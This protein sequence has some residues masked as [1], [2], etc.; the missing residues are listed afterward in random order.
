LHGGQLRQIS[1][2]FNIPSSQL[3]D[4]SANIN[5]DGPPPGVIST[6][7]TSVEDVS[8]LTAYPDLEQ[9]AL[10]QSIA[11]YGGMGP[12]NLAV[13][14]GF[15]PLLEA[16]LRTLNIKRCLL[17]VPAFVEYRRS[18][19]RAGVKI[20]PHILT[21]ESNFRY[22][23]DALVN[24]DHDAVLLANPQNP[25]GVLTNREVLLQLVSKCAER[26]TTVLLDEAFID[27]AP[28]DSLTQD[29]ER[30][31]N[32]IVFRS[33]TKFYG[34]P[35]LRVAYAVAPATIARV[36]NEN[37]SPWPVTTLASCA[38]TSALA[39]NLFA[40]RSR[41]YNDRRKK[42]LEAGLQAYGIHTYP[43][44]A[45]FLLFRLPDAISPDCFWRRMIVEHHIVLRDCSNYEA[46]PSGHFRTAVRGEEQNELLVR[47]VFPALRSC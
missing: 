25:S 11:H 41:L 20:K 7:R 36:L 16:A 34:I 1:E 31:T 18:L 29:V 17:P 28:L 39:D 46:L 2:R 42:I 4:F 10:K 27:Y 23:I 26:G 38:V 21:P 6:L 9:T 22:D 8:M 30:F 47:A 37:L 35:G 40:D 43:S 32:L 33:V 44:A 45:N 12:Q 3:I 24:G 13:A 19:V 15:V 14:N 5:P